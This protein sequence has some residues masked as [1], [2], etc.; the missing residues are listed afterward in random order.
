MDVSRERGGALNE[1]VTTV[2]LRT[3]KMPSMFRLWNKKC[4][5][6]GPNRRC[7]GPEQYQKLFRFD[8]YHPLCGVDSVCLQISSMDTV[9]CCGLLIQMECHGLLSVC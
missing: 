9:S 3:E 7:S 1:T 8:L 5:E 2:S 6:T 4:S